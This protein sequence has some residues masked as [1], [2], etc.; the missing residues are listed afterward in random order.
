VSLWALISSGLLPTRKNINY[1]FL[2]CKK[3][4][5]QSEK[6]ERRSK[7]NHRVFPSLMMMMM[8]MYV[9]SRNRRWLP[10]YLEYN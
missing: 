4:A 8:M 1:E 2:L 6:C 3:V 9:I 5:L 7:L 10:S